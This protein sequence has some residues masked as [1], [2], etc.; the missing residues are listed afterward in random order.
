[1]FCKNLVF[2]LS[3]A[4]FKRIPAE[5]YRP[6]HLSTASSFVL[7]LL[8]SMFRRSK[9]TSHQ[10]KMR[11]WNFIYTMIHYPWYSVDAT[12]L[13]TFT[14]VH[15]LP[16]PTLALL[17]R[18]S[19]LFAFSLSHTWFNVQR[20]VATLVVRL[21]GYN[22][23]HLSET[24]LFVLNR[25]AHVVCK[26]FEKST[27]HTNKQTNEKRNERKEKYWVEFHLKMNWQ[28]KW[29]FCFVLCF[30][31]VISFAHF[32]QHHDMQIDFL[33]I[34]FLFFDFLSFIEINIS[35]Q[36]SKIRKFWYWR[37]CIHCSWRHSVCLQSTDYRYI[38]Y[39]CLL[40]FFFIVLR[41]NGSEERPN[42]FEC[43]IRI[44]LN[45]KFLHLANCC[46]RYD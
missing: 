8:E 12:A 23:V 9:K 7:R 14:K 44:E 28:R 45:H 19:L 15:T 20:K 24:P 1:M 36:F 30:Q 11:L 5:M 2:L 27:K 6:C 42:Q 40:H 10:I 16:I 46:N 18:H 17:L 41:V 32:T 35:V 29:L 43:F 4:C 38:I 31:S 22:A 26:I 37:L 13:F 25:I 34:Y 21:Y 3:L 39:I 33:W